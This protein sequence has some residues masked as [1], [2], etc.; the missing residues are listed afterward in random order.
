MKKGNF[1]DTIGR[2]IT[3]ITDID[4]HNI[5][6]VSLFHNHFTFEGNTEKNKY[7][8]Q[9]FSSKGKPKNP[10]FLYEIL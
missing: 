6:K 8:A 5:N 3:D 7:L 9:S 2:N 10:F 4:F 1:L